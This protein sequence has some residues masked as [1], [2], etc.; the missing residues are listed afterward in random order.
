MESARVGTPQRELHVGPAIEQRDVARVEV[1]GEEA[2]RIYIDLM[3]CCLNDAVEN[4][5]R[6]GREAIN[7]FA[8]GDEQRMMLLGLKRFTKAA[9]FNTKDARRRLA[10]RLIAEGKYGM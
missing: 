3:K 7:A 2:S 10:D 1:R 8:E 5:G 6:A 4:A 9:P